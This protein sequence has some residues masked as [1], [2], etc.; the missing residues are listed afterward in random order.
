MNVK[1]MRTCFLFWAL[2][3][4]LWFIYDVWVGLYSRAILDIV[5]L[6]FAIWGYYEWRGVNVNR[7]N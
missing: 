3:N 6:G 1:K 5:Q 7:K 4:I 2:G